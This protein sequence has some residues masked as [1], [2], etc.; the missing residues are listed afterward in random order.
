LTAD[1]YDF[2]ASFAYPALSLP[3]DS[4][5]E[6]EIA[7]INLGYKP[8][9]FE[10]E[11]IEAPEGW[12][13]EIRRFNTVFSSIFLSPEETA[14][15]VLT[16]TPP[17]SSDGLP[18][19]EYRFAVRISSGAGGKTVERRA[20]VLV[21]EFASSREPLSI[22]TSYPEIGGPSD[23]RFAFS[24]DI[25]NDGREDALI[26]LLAEAPQGWEA[27]FKPGYEDKQISS[28]HVPKG[29]SR[30]VTLD[31][32]PVFQAEPGS[33]QIAVKAEQ[34]AGSA[35]VELTV[36]LT[37][38][39]KIRALTAN[40]LLSSVAEAGRP[41]TLTLFVLNEGSAP[42]PEISFLAVNPDN[43]KV[44]FKP[45]TIRDLPARSN[46][47]EVAMTITPAEGALV[48][49]YALGVSV[50]GERSQT[51][52]D[53][54]ITVKAGSAM[55]WLGAALVAIV[56]MGLALTFRKLGRR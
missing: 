53:F 51:A 56:I 21:Q 6:L 54:R 45:E 38:T 26:N 15:I 46:P 18:S 8:D 25:S 4:E 50:Q 55:A 9:T 2:E 28:I 39:Y 47:V 44:E 1:P 52:L 7:L 24:L 41:V 31:L 11:V 40:D 17:E 23:G 27:S 22:N 13:T 20:K 32:T 29:Q 34:P 30:S 43:W 33:Y 14:P 16:A 36:N 12:K 3:P 5:A 42:Q 19:G 37:G 49:D 48:G 35:R 10:I